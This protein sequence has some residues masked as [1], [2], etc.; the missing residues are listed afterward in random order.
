MLCKL[1]LID[2][3]DDSAERLV[4]CKMPLHGFC[5]K[6]FLNSIFWEKIY[7]GKNYLWMMGK[8]STVF[9][10]E[11]SNKTCYTILHSAPRLVQSFCLSQHLSSCCISFQLNRKERLIMPPVI[12]SACKS[13]RGNGKGNMFRNLDGER[14]KSYPANSALCDI[15]LLLWPALRGE[16]SEEE[17]NDGGQRQ[18]HKR[19]ANSRNIHCGFG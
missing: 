12:P 15:H 18:K 6:S 3:M 5:P 13:E 16:I 2:L 9:K 17:C 10:K 7:F 19:N 14:I 11:V 8:G 1:H 4:F